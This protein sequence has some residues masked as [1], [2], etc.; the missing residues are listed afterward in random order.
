MKASFLEL[1][2]QRRSEGARG[3]SSA[4]TDAVGGAAWQMAA[5][6]GVEWAQVSDENS[7]GRSCMEEPE[8][9]GTR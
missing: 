1:E 4:G 2:L 6:L 3:R 7:G 8:P 9:Q 5:E